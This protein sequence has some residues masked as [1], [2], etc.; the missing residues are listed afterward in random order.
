MVSTPTYYKLG[1][2]DLTG[3]YIRVSACGRPCWLGASSGTDPP[4]P[5]ASAIL[6]GF[7]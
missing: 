7:L 3:D 5:R 6:V 2:T 1:V 4:A